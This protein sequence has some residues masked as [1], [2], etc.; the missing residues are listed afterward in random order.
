MHIRI[1]EG[2]SWRY[3]KYLSLRM[4]SLGSPRRFI[5]QRCN[6]LQCQA[7]ANVVSYIYATPGNTGDYLSMRG[8]RELSREPGYILQCD[9]YSLK[10]TFQTL[11]NSSNIK[12]IV[13]GGGGLIQPVFNEFWDRIMECHLPYALFGVGV[14][15]LPH[16]REKIDRGRLK[17]ICSNAVSVHVRDLESKNILRESSG[18]EDITTGVCPSVNF[19]AHFAVQDSSNH[20][21]LLHVL[22][23]SDLV[24]SHVDVSRLIKTVQ[25]LAEQLGLSYKQT[26]HTRGWSRFQLRQY[27]KSSVVI[28]SRLHGCIIAYALG[29]P[30][31]PIVCDH[32][33]QWFVDTHATGVNTIPAASVMDHL[34]VEFV[35]S[36]M[37]ST[38][39]KSLL[40][41]KLSQNELAMARAK[42]ALGLS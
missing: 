37:N 11:S 33:T 17:A 6:N 22:H 21:T 34:D 42:E 41:E 8:V 2:L 16:H 18:R 5:E 39:D 26:E 19:L 10:K 12:G 36:V 20:Q 30:F 15:Y 4:D 24:A 7:R 32:K 13:I 25:V 28:S 40:S 9:S 27:M 38:V 3:R 14:N 23:P 31:V 29:K 1:R 35:E